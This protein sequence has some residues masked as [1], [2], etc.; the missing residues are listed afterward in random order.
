VNIAIVGTRIDEE[1]QPK[2]Y[3]DVKRLVEMYVETLPSDTLVVSGGAYGVDTMAE[4]AARARG[5]KT[6][7]IRADWRKMGVRAGLIR[8]SKIVFKADKVVAFWNQESRG[9][10]DTIEKAR[11]NNKEVEIINVANL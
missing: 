4:D 3:Q 11:A 5:L 8:N 7:I 6:H 10:K 1:T 9:T 2:L